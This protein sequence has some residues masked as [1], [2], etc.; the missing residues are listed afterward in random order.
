MLL[1]RINGLTERLLPSW[2]DII[3]RSVRIYSVRDVYVIHL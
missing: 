2:N 1:R 3:R